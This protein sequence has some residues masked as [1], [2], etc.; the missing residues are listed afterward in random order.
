MLEPRPAWEPRQPQTDQNRPEQQVVAVR[1]S[2]QQP[3]RRCEDEPSPPVALDDVE[4]PER[5]LEG[6][7]RGRLAA[8]V[9]VVDRIDLL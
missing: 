3:G 5:T 1:Q 4:L 6:E 9:G 2:L 7:L 8:I